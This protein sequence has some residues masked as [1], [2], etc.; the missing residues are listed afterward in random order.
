MILLLHP[1]PVSDAGN[2]IT[3]LGNINNSAIHSS[4]SAPGGG[5]VLASGNKQTISGNGSGRFGNITINNA[6]GVSM[7]DDSRITGQLNLSLGS[8][9]IDDYKLIMDV[10]ASF[11]GPFDSKHMIESNGVLSDEGVQ[12]YFSG[13]AAG[14][15]FPVG[16][17]KKYRPAIFTFTSANG[18]S[19]KVVPVALTHPADNA[20][21]NDQLNY[22]WKIL[23]TGFSGLTS[24][25]QIYQY[26][27]IRC[28][29][30]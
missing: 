12:K 21:T 18:G 9:Y 10:D 7:V 17:N 14:F 29:W 15:V 30:Q 16:S 13:S 8:L 2:T 3:V 24:S 27:I 11:S 4:P 22:Y 23:T 5:I 28:Q 20:P 19:I 1:E 26:G 25:S 6:T